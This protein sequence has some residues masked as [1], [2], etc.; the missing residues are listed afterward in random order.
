MTWNAV[1]FPLG[2]LRGVATKGGGRGA[3]VHVL[4]LI[5]SHALVVGRSSIPVGAGLS[6][7]KASSSALSGP[8]E[9]GEALVRVWGAPS[10]PDW[11]A[12]VLGR[13]L[14]SATDRAVRQA[15]DLINAAA[16]LM[17]RLDA[18]EL[19][20]QN[21]AGEAGVSVRVL[22]RHF[23]GKDDLLVALIE[24]CQIVFAR[25]IEKATADIADPL[26]R[27]GEALYFATT[28]ARQQT[29]QN[30]SR[31]MARFTIQTSVTSPDQV[32][33][34]HRPVIL[35]LATMVEDAM[36]SG[37]VE[38][39]DSEVAASNLWDVY[40]AHQRNVYLGNSPSSPRAASGQLIRFCLL[41]LGARIPPGWEN[42]LGQRKR[43]Q[44]IAAS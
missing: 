37:L 42:Q 43:G 34:A 19:T 29:D 40:E 27:L 26:E 44:S 33:A 41:G 6:M 3:G 39:G 12:R 35:V 14:G 8:E 15:R 17:R 23:E 31:A 22:Y 10:M 1:T 25:L 32:G 38:V 18:E 2:P 20:M 16:R 13:S 11:Q 7:P 28:E 24:E 36:R 9:R 5:G 21:I 4:D 30:F